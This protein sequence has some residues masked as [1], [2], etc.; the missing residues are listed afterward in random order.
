MQHIKEPLEY[1]GP[2]P[3]DE[4][5]SLKGVM[6]LEEWEELALPIPSGVIYNADYGQKYTHAKEK[7]LV[8]SGISNSEQIALK[9]RKEKTWHLVYV[10][11]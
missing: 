3:E 4:S 11:Y 8:V 5:R 10:E 6:T 1:R 7:I 2:D 9:F